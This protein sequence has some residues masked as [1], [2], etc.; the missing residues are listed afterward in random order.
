MSNSISLSKKANKKQA[1]MDAAFT[2]FVHD[3]FSNVKVIDIADKAGIGKGTFYEYF[4]SKNDIFLEFLEYMK[5]EF[6]N[7]GKYIDELPTFKAKLMQLITFEF[8]FLKKYGPH[9]AE[10][11]Q[12]TISIKMQT[13][14]KLMDSIS[15]LLFIEYNNIANIVKFGIETGD[16]KDCDISTAV[17]YIATTIASF[18]FISTLQSPC[19]FYKHIETDYIRRYTTDEIYELVMNGLHS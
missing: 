4:K 17:Y 6:R 19:S 13:S 12:S 15:E 1:I 18:T 8:D 14:S 5:E 11:K 16:V 9:A 10:I 7:L 3:G 2:L